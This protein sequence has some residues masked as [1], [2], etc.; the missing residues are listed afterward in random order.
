VPHATV[1]QLLLELVAGILD[2]L[3]GGLDVVDADAG[4]A[5]AA[6][7]LLVTG[8]DGEVGVVLSAVVVG[9]LGIEE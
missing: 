4:V 7:R 1:G 3:A 6:V 5:E 8:S 9:E 2:A